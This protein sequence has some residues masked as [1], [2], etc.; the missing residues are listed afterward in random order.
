MV[1]PVTFRTSGTVAG[2]NAPILASAFIE[3]KSAC[4]FP[5]AVPSGGGVSSCFEDE[6]ALGTKDQNLGQC[7]LAASALRQVAPIAPPSAASAIANPSRGSA[8]NAATAALR[9]RLVD[10]GAGIQR[11]EDTRFILRFSR[12]IGSI[13]S[14]NSAISHFSRHRK[15]P[16]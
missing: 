6:S 9:C 10:F 7:F 12:S 5:A 15:R 11:D 8:S 14:S 4:P 3:C 1:S 16:V 2:G 13:T